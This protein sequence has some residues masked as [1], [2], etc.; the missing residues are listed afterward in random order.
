MRRQ[1]RLSIAG[2]RKR[3]RAVSAATVAA[4]AWWSLSASACF[5]MPL[6]MADDE[7]P[8][9]AHVEHDMTA[10][11]ATHAPND[12]HEHADMP[13]CAHCPPP[14]A[15]SQSAPTV[16]ATDGTSNVNGPKP[17]ATPDLFKLFT[18]SRL[19]TLSWTAAPPPL[20][21]TAAVSRVPFEHTP[22]NVRHCVFLI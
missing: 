11:P 18:Q 6:G 9:V 7:A 19:P 8:V 1:A 15:D 21:P 22:L 13:D 10:P 20:I 4:F 14:A 16:C 5:G 17:S 12:R 2:L 3:R